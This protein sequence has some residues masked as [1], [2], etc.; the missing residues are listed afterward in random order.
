MAKQRPPLPPLQPMPNLERLLAPGEEIIYTVRLHPLHGF[1]WAFS[2]LVFLTLAYWWIWFLPLGLILTFIY[3]MPFRTN[4]IAVTTQRLLIRKGRF[5]LRLEGVMAKSVEDWRLI[6]SVAE[7]LLHC[8]DV[9]VTVIENRD[10][11]RIWLPTL[12]HPM[13]FI[14]ALET[15]Q[16]Q[17][18][19]GASSRATK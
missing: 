5:R 3:F 14:E 1:K 16:L 7:S 4:E 19:N 8:G 9:E 15:L 2:A 18:R 12:W 11:R 17:P 10:L 13:T 6:Q